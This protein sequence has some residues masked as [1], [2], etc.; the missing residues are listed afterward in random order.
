VKTTTQGEIRAERTTLIKPQSSQS[1]I[2]DRNSNIWYEDSVGVTVYSP[3]TNKFTHYTEKD[4]L[5]SNRVLS[6]LEDHKGKIW[7]ATA[8]GITTYANGKFSILPIPTSTDGFSYY[9]ASSNTYPNNEI[10]INLK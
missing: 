1:I 9:N 2:Q 4:G 8:N 10:F 3:S 7:L 6:I 5:S